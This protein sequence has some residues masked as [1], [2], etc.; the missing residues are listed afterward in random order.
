MAGVMRYLPVLLVL[1]GCIE[2]PWEG[3][4][5]GNTGGSVVV[6]KKNVAAHDLP[7]N[8]FL[9]VDRSSTLSPRLDEVRAALERVVVARQADY[10]FGLVLAPA[11]AGCAVPGPAIAPGGSVDELV[12][13]LRGLTTQGVPSLAAG[14]AAVPA[15]ETG[16]R[17]AAVLLT[18]SDDDHCQGD[19]ASAAQ[20]LY[21]RLVPTHVVNLGSY[22]GILEATAS[23]GGTAPKCVDKLDCPESSCDLSTAR[24]LKATHDGY[25]AAS[26]AQA[27]ASLFPAPTP[28]SCTFALDTEPTNAMRVTVLMDGEKLRYPFDWELVPAGVQL[29]G[30][31]CDRVTASTAADPVELEFQVETRP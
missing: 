24:C 27:L 18:A 2:P 8:V 15:R 19:V 21:Q 7:P 3:P 1:L 14:L 30:A 28:P 10:R 13:A 12:G 16:R 11:A 5:P 23:G 9:V 31:A 17:S 6:Q 29:F 20:A 4:P 22:S 25:D 26:L